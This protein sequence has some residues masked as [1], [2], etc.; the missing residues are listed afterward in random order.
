MT[1]EE[2]RLHRLQRL[3][4]MRAICP[5]IAIKP[6]FQHRYKV[7]DGVITYKSIDARYFTYWDVSKGHGPDKSDILG[8][9]SRSERRPW[10]NVT[11]GFVERRAT[12]WRIVGEVR[13]YSTPTAALV[14]LVRRYKGGK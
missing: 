10:L 13:E 7:V 2:M 5:D 14:E 8:N 1:L 3:S 9:I 4:Q 12:K 11:L 6:K